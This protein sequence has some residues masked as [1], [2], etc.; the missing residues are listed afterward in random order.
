[1][2]EKGNKE[3]GC[4]Y[5]GLELFDMSILAGSL[6][7]DATGIWPNIPWQWIAI[8]AA[9]IFVFLT[10]RRIIML[11]RI[12]WA[13]TPSIKLKR[14]YVNESDM[15]TKLPIIISAKEE[16]IKTRPTYFAHAVFVNEPKRGTEQNHANDVRI[17]LTYYDKRGQVILDKIDGRWSG[18]DFPETP[19]DIQRVIRR[20][21]RSDGSNET[22]DIALKP[23]NSETWYAKTNQNY[24]FNDMIDDSFRLHADVVD[25]NM[26]LRGERVHRDFW[27]RMH[28]KGKDNGIIIEERKSWLKRLISQKQ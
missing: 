6:F 12:M 17:V 19:N 24:F 18:S 15:W 23:K 20:R 14:T 2:D 9:I 5:W 21:I 13:R 16:K 27:V 7:L 1:M 25:V 4:I 28:N 26:E 11:E 8:G 10:W 3:T 22:I